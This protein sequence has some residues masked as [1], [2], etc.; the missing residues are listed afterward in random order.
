MIRNEEN[1]QNNLLY[2]IIRKILFYIFNFLDL[3]IPKDKK[4]IIFGSQFGIR[5]FDNS[6]YLY[7]YFLKNH[8]DEFDIYWATS[9]NE[10]Y[11]LVLSKLSNKNIFLINRIQSLW[12]LCRAK[13]IVYS[14]SRGDFIGLNFSK[15]KNIIY[16]DHG[17]SLKSIG[18]TENSLTISE[19]KNMKRY[20]TSKYTMVIAS[21]PTEKSNLAISWN[22]ST[23]K[24]KI[25][26]YP[27]NDAL[28]NEDI[29]LLEKYPFLKQK[30]I[31][32]APTFRDNSKTEL[33]PFNDLNIQEIND[34]LEK[35]NIYLLLRG[36]ATETIFRKN[37]QTENYVNDRIISVNQ[38]KFENVNELLPFI[39]ILI[40][41]YSGIYID[42]LLLNKP[43]IFIPYDLKIYEEERGLLFNY[44]GVTPGA[45]VSTQ[46]ELL[47]AFKIYLENPKKDESQRKIIKNLFHTYQDNKS[48]Y[49]VYKEIK[50]LLKLENK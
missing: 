44:H 37:S 24:I 1:L 16:L 19:K 31:L 29:S 22:I 45:K 20:E 43:M 48:S 25:T 36:H 49:R 39:D 3:I 18:Y 23:D 46:E 21:S 9:S 10:I 47:H 35:E 13:T 50:E 4:L 28:F 5:Y 6:Q 15:R 32:Y 34:F 40:S 26:G 27:R 30:V 17:I 11:Q 33:F 14:Y 8:S 12:L 2:K 38:D 42:F 41:D 7:E